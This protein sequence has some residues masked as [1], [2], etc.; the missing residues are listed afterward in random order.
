MSSVLPASEPWGRAPFNILYGKRALTPGEIE[1]WKLNHQAARRQKPQLDP[2]PL[3]SGIAPLTS[4]QPTQAASPPK[5]GK[6]AQPARQGNHSC[7]ASFNH[8]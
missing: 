1:R 5:G 6:P 4:G 8:R 2:S 3:A 7:L